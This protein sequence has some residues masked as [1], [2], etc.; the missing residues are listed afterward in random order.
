MQQVVADL[1]HLRLFDVYKSKGIYKEGQIFK[2][3]ESS[4][5]KA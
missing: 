1:C 3:K 4:K 5:S 2:L